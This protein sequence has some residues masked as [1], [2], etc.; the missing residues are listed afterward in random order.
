MLQVIVLIKISKLSKI[1][2]GV[3]LRK[4]QHTSYIVLYTYLYLILYL[5]IDGDP[6]TGRASIVS[7]TAR[8]FNGT[9]ITGNRVWGVVRGGLEEKRVIMYNRDNIINLITRPSFERCIHMNVCVILFLFNVTRYVLYV[10]S[11]CKYVLTINIFGVLKL[12][13]V[14]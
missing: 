10:L 13:L 4:F 14:A 9:R 3:S 2:F 8:T 1:D 12:T 7:E 11:M 5:P 6:P